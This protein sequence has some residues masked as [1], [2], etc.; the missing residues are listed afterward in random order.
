M[1]RASRCKDDPRGHRF[2][3]RA[4]DGYCYC[5]AWRTNDRGGP[6]DPYPAD[7]CRARIKDAT[8]TLPPVTVRW[9]GR[10]AS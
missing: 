7:R 9:W 6:M 2:G 4:A 5:E 10:G 1:T 8:D 3:P